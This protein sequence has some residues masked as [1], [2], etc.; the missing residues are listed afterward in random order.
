ML[1]VSMKS[2]LA[3]DESDISSRGIDSGIREKGWPISLG[4]EG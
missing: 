3:F 2:L 1:R 4:V